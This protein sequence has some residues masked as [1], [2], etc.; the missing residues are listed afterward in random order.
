MLDYIPPGLEKFKL[1]LLR[2]LIPALVLSIHS[3]VGFAIR[4]DLEILTILRKNIHKFA[5]SFFF[6]FFL[7][8][9]LTIP[10]D[11]LTPST[12]TKP[13]RVQLAAMDRSRATVLLC[14]VRSVQTRS[15]QH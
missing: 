13:Q 8:V 7:C 2:A 14:L 10:L 6:F 15:C 3:A 4:N 5:R 11:V 12:V 1:R 9:S